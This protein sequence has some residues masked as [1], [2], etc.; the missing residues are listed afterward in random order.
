M[1]HTV[2][3][4]PGFEDWVELDVPE[5]ADKYWMPQPVGT[6][7]FVRVMVEEMNPNHRFAAFGPNITLATA[8]WFA[9][10]VRLPVDLHPGDVVDYRHK[11][12]GLP[13]RAL[14]LGPN[15]WVVITS[16][17]QHYRAKDSYLL[18]T[19]DAQGFRRWGMDALGVMFG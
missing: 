17:E 16:A 19:V 13:V 11:D 18:D 12:T 10:P 9:E 6:R 7:R 2:T 5:G 4:P 14:H 1:T 15:E 8:R 3:L